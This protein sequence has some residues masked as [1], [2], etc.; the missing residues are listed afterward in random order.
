MGLPPHLDQPIRDPIL[1]R[2]SHHH[3]HAPRY[4]RGQ[5]C[6]ALVD[7]RFLNWLLATDLD[8]MGDDKLNRHALHGVF[9]ALMQQSPRRRRWPII[10]LLSVP[11]L[12]GGWFALWHYAAGRAETQ[13]DR[14]DGPWWRLWT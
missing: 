14:A 2:E 9:T 6:I 4:D 3:T 7:G 11:V 10:L 12:A 1:K 13:T 5:D 8:G